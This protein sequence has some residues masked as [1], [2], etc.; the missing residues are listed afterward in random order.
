MTKHRMGWALAGVAIGAAWIL[1]VGQ[2]WGDASTCSPSALRHLEA[3]I[4]SAT[5]GSPAHLRLLEERDAMESPA[6]SPASPGDLRMV[7]NGV[8]DKSPC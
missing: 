3:A 7:E 1:P 2:A 8:D 6:F 5:N 4:A